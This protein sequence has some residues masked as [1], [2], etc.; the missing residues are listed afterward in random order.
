M[1]PF[2][3]ILKKVCKV[4][5]KD[6]IFFFLSGNLLKSSYT[7]S[8]SLDRSPVVRFSSRWPSPISKHFAFGWSLKGSSMFKTETWTTGYTLKQCYKWLCY[9]NFPFVCATKE[10]GDVC[11]ETNRHT[12]G[13][14]MLLENNVVDSYQVMM[15]SCT[16][17]YASIIFY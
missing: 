9:T 17:C 7:Q 1:K 5:E 6:I 8:S 12:W 14:W 15:F 10:L 3:W 2:K 13:T 11:M 4:H 16:D